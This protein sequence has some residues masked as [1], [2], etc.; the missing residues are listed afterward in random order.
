MACGMMAMK[1]GQT[2]TTNSVTATNGKAKIMAIWRN[3]NADHNDEM[4][5]GVTNWA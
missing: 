2:M 5:N 1:C 4:T 3:G